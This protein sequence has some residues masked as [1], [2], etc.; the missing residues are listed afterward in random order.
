[1]SHFQQDIPDEFEI[2]APAVKKQQKVFKSILKLDRN[3]HVYIH[4][5]REMI[6]RGFDEA[7]NMNYYKL[8]FENE[9]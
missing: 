3:F 6:E 4:G 5:N 2:S 7:T 1:A 9:A 8:L